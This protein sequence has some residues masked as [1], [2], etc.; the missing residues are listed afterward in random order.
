M[1]DQTAALYAI[2]ARNVNL[3]VIVRGYVK[4]L[5]EGFGEA[6]PPRKIL[7]GGCSAAKP[8]YNRQKVGLRG[9][10]SPCALD[11]D[12]ALDHVNC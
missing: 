9:A 4:V 8:H 10:T 3:C 5:I 1:P 11:F 7:S 2:R 12:M 6:K